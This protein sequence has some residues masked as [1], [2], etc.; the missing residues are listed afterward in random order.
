MTSRGPLRPSFETQ[1]STVSKFLR[2]DCQKLSP[3][4]GNICLARPEHGGSEN[5]HETFETDMHRWA[6]KRTRRTM[7]H[8]VPI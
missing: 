5:G 6:G 1:R 8:C 7:A 3:R 4:I 2:L